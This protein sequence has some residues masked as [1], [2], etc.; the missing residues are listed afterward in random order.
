MLQGL[1]TLKWHYP[2]SKNAGGQWP[3]TSKTAWRR[4]LFQSPCLCQSISANLW[5]CRT[6]KLGMLTEK[7]QQNCRCPQ[8]T[9][10][11]ALCK[12]RH[13]LK[14]MGKKHKKEWCYNTKTTT[15]VSGSLSTVLQHA[16]RHFGVNAF[17]ESSLFQ[18]YTDRSWPTPLLSITMPQGW[19]VCGLLATVE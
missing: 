4:T 1:A 19:D 5:T 8:I 16:K 14:V 11:L 10:W 15:Q 3:S 2:R 9:Q 12:T 18:T 6:Y 13:I 17:L 7:T